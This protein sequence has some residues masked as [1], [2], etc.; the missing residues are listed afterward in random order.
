VP[1]GD[2]GGGAAAS[3]A[4]AAEAWPPVL[5]QAPSSGEG[6]DSDD[7]GKAERGERGERGGA[8]GHPGA[9]TARKAS[10]AARRAGAV[11]H[12]SAVVDTFSMLSAAVDVFARTVALG[13]GAQPAH[14]SAML[15]A[16]SAAVRCVMM[17]MTIRGCVTALGAV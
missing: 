7:S 1:Q 10:R 2:G 15:R 9:G 16:T 12:S 6:S 13:V 11:L 8:G 14:L 4:E 17:T 3:A 5:L